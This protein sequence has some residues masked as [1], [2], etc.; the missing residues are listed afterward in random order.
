[1]IR[2]EKD[3]NIDQNEEQKTIGGGTMVSFLHHP[4]SEKYFWWEAVDS[5]CAAD[6]VKSELTALFSDHRLE[7]ALPYY[8]PC[9]HVV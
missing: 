8:P 2:A 9:R 4:Y 5:V 1:M 6:D 7:R 3:P